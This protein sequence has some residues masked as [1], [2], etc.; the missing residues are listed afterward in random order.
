MK[1]PQKIIEV[2]SFREESG[3]KGKN[4]LMRMSYKKVSKKP[5][6]KSLKKFKRNF[7]SVLIQSK[8][9]ENKKSCLS[10]MRERSSSNEYIDTINVPSN[11]D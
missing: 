10:S 11:L 1:I 7:E 6:A 9:K 5:P 2:S 3:V 4:F 8:L